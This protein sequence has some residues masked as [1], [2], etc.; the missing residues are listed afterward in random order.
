MQHY[1]TSRFLTQIR[2]ADKGEES[3]NKVTGG[4]HWHVMET[5]GEEDGYGH[6]KGTNDFTDYK[7]YDSAGAWKSVLDHL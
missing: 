4:R 1:D 5:G 7:I 3:Y 2:F 6:D